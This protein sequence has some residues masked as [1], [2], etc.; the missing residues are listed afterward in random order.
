MHREIHKS[1]HITVLIIAT[2]IFL[3]G[4][5]VGAQ[6]EQF[7]LEKLEREFREQSRIS[8][9]MQAEIEYINYLLDSQ[10]NNGYSCQ[11][12]VNSYLDSIKRLDDI[13]FSLER[14]ESSAITRLEDYSLIKENYFNLQT[15]Y[16]IL[17][18]RVNSL[19]PNS[20]DTI[21]YFY[22]NEKDCPECEDQGLFLDHIKR[23][24]Q[25]NVMI[26]S[27]DIQ[28]S[29]T[30]VSMLSNNNQ[31]K[32]YEVPTLIINGEN[33]LDFS[34]VEIIEQFLEISMEN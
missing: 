18:N 3:L 22:T 19:C 4:I 5:L 27:F 9:E 25:N 29:V 28:S 34:N 12:L 13:V 31:V 1:R 30:I 2:I 16:Y 6:V 20:F 7:R 33:R 10:R 8:D 32:S 24:H 26:F 17:G 21:L 14:Y 15:R 11:L 23:K